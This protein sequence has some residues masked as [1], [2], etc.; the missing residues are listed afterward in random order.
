MN[1]DD[2]RMT[3]SLQC[4]DEVKHRVKK[5]SGASVKW[6]LCCAAVSLCSVHVPADALCFSL[7]SGPDIISVALCASPSYF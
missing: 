1:D 3:H 7:V 4:V 6:R 2:M 5:G